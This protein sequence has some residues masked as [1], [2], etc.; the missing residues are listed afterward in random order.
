MRGAVKFSIK[1][2]NDN[3]LVMNTSEIGNFFD[4]E[5]DNI[6]VSSV[7]P[8]FIPLYVYKCLFKFG[9]ALMNTSDFQKFKSSIPWLLNKDMK[10]KGNIPY[11][12]LLN[13]QTKPVVK[14][15]AILL[16]RKKEYNSPEY[17]LVFQWG[18]Y[19]FQIFLPFNS[20]DENLDYNELKFP[21]FENFVIK[22]NK[23]NFGL[24]YYDMDS[25]S[26]VKSIYDANFGLKNFKKIKSPLI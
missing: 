11:I 23:G 19:F 8:P 26:K 16:K 2:R 10:I 9:L 13:S 5:N 12:M 6:K 25:L 17:S 22:N 14:P 3:T 15:I 21:V 7:T 4:I 1:Y 24:S 18:F 20:L